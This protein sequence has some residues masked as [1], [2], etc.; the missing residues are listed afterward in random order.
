VPPVELP[1]NLFEYCNDQF[2][3]IM[4]GFAQTGSMAIQMTKDWCAMN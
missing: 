3:E 4:M 1:S 2:S